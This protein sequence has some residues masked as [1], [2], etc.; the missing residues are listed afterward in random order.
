VSRMVPFLSRRSGSRFNVNDYLERLGKEDFLG[1]VGR[2]AGEGRLSVLFVGDA[3]PVKFSYAGYLYFLE[4]MGGH[5]VLHI[6]DT[7]ELGMYMCNGKIGMIEKIVE[8][9][10]Y[11]KLRKKLAFYMPEDDAR[12]SLAR[13]LRV[14]PGSTRIVFQPGRAVYSVMEHLEKCLSQNPLDFQNNYGQLTLT[15]SQ[16]KEL[17]KAHRKNNC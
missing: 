4:D 5:A 10:K 11:M 8:A 1:L 13:I 12:I 14:L 9:N 6:C 2:L 3:D 17:I 16:L 15:A 7:T